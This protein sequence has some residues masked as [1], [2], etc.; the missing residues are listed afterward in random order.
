VIPKTESTTFPQLSYKLGVTASVSKRPKPIIQHT[1][2]FDTKGETGI[3]LART[4]IKEGQLVQ[5]SDP[6][7]G[8]V[9]G[10]S[11]IESM[12]FDL[13]SHEEYDGTL[14]LKPEVLVKQQFMSMVSRPELKVKQLPSISSSSALS[15]AQNVLKD[16]V[17]ERLGVEL[18]WDYYYEE[19][20][21]PRFSKIF[22]KRNSSLK[23]VNM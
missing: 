6:R 2:A 20:Q 1:E 9:Q 22:R 11:Y 18:G 23:R 15:H 4:F 14:P 19:E 5:H 21:T 3:E 13:K 17:L 8:V 16:T 7:I 12:F 10:P